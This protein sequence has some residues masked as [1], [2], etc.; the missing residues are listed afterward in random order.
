MTSQI[1]WSKNPHVRFTTN[2]EFETNLQLI[3]P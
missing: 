1:R 3:S 2:E